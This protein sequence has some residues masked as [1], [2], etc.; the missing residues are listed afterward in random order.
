L[1]HSSTY[2]QTSPRLIQECTSES[3]REL[4]SDEADQSNR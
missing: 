3:C 4:P 1:D 2:P